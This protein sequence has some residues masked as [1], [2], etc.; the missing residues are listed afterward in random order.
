MDKKNNKVVTFI[1]G[2]LTI[3]LILIILIIFFLFY[4]GKTNKDGN[5]NNNVNSNESFNYVNDAN[6][7][8]ELDTWEKEESEQEKE[9]KIVEKTD[10]YTYLLLSQCLNKYFQ[11]SKIAFELIDIEAKRELNITESNFGNFFKENT[12]FCIDK[13]YK[14]ELRNGKIIYVVSLRIS[15]RSPSTSFPSLT[16][17][18][19]V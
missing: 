4:C 5:N 14:E 18:V 3:A 13:I 15:T 16:E 6:F 2:I 8:Q 12:S 17:I 7:V 11:S 1:I 10:N 19:Y 9:I